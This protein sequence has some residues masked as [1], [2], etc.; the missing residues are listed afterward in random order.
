MKSSHAIR[1]RRRSKKAAGCL[2]GYGVATAGMTSHKTASACRD[3]QLMRSC[4]RIGGTPTD[5]QVSSRLRRRG[6]RDGAH[7]A[8]QLA[9]GENLNSRMRTYFTLR[10]QLGSSYL[11]LLQFFLNHRRF[12]RSRVDRQGKSARE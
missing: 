7:V 6:K 9:G 8:L 1:L 2:A 11:D 12:M 4:A 5:G 3:G 10:R